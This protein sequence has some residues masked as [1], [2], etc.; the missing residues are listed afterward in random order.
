VALLDYSCGKA[1]V[2]L[3]HP[4]QRINVAWG[5]VKILN[6]AIVGAPPC[7]SWGRMAAILRKKRLKEW[8]R[9]WKIHLIE[10]M[11]PE[12]IDLFDDQTGEI[13]DGPADLSRNR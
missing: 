12:W 2:D 10:S 8:R 9:L 13:L 3:S 1:R 4:H 6:V 11:N 7:P 5:V